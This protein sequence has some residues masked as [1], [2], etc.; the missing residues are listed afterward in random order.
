MID[1]YK[2]NGESKTAD[3]D[4]YNEYSMKD[5]DVADEINSARITSEANEESEVSR[6]RGQITPMSS[7]GGSSIQ[8]LRTSRPSR[9]RTKS[10]SR[11][12]LYSPRHHAKRGSFSPSHQRVLI[13][14]VRDLP[15]DSKNTSPTPGNRRHK[16]VDLDEIPETRM[17]PRFQGAAR[18]LEQEEDY[19]EFD[20]CDNPKREGERGETARLRQE[21]KEM[22]EM[23]IQNG[24]FLRISAGL[25]ALGHDPPV[26]MHPDSLMATAN[27]LRDSM[28][29]ER[30]GRARQ[31]GKVWA[32]REETLTLQQTQTQANLQHLKAAA[33]DM[34]RSVAEAHTRAAHLAASEARRGARVALKAARLAERTGEELRPLEFLARF[35]ASHQALDEVSR[36]EEKYLAAGGGD[37]QK[38]AGEI[39]SSLEDNG[40]MMEVRSVRAL[41][42]R[43]RL[44]SGPEA[45]H[46]QTPRSRTLR[47]LGGLL[48]TLTLTTQEEEESEGE[49]KAGEGFSEQEV[50]PQPQ[51]VAESKATKAA[52]KEAPSHR[53]WWEGQRAIQ[54]LASQLLD[55]LSH[56]RD[57]RS[58]LGRAAQ[59]KALVVGISYKD[60]ASQQSASAEGAVIHALPS[61][62]AADARSMEQLLISRLGF[63]DSEESMRVLVD[64]DNWQGE[65]A[66]PTCRQIRSSIQWLL[67][68]AQPGDQLFFYFSGLSSQVLDEE[69]DEGG[70]MVNCLCP[71]DMLTINNDRCITED[72]LRTSLLLAL[73]RGVFLTVIVDAGACTLAHARLPV[74]STLPE[75]EPTEEKE[76]RGVRKTWVPPSAPKL[77][78]EE[79]AL[80][81]KGELRGVWAGGA[82]R[83]ARAM[84]EIKSKSIVLLTA[85]SDTQSAREADLEDGGACRGAATWALQQALQED[86]SNDP[87]PMIGN[88]V[89][90]MNSRL[91]DAGFEQQAQLVVGETIDNKSCRLLY[92][93]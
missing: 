56:P 18:R 11:S 62:G 81:V 52:M 32:E 46:V 10:R 19:E 71:L 9:Q 28:G 2:E 31:L 36:I 15:R 74:P 24:L 72:E 37:V 86:F 40:V 26:D 57:M 22:R 16:Y 30:S 70:G 83:R 91:K 59:R 8:K 75:A 25:R 60:F 3:S 55:P 23:L 38:S 20:D 69:G 85:S 39:V 84:T 49:T 43:P 87:Y 7:P 50:P 47:L 82:R 17:V 73:P 93:N 61:G 27:K 45:A 66:L 67:R 1:I 65:C 42:A 68:G 34:Y 80:P 63:S 89:E 35:V 14:E 48:D 12:P 4:T 64:G 33:K 58:L 21:N 76:Q 54:A 77:K 29:S 53:V 88:L 13:G 5:Y 51:P 41:A 90:R 44:L 6:G 79:P 92:S 78:V